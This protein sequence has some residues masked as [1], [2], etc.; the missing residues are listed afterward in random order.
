MSI[1]NDEPSAS[2]TETLVTPPSC[3]AGVQQGSP[4]FTAVARIGNNLAGGFWEYSINAKTGHYAYGPTN[5]PFDTQVVAF[6][7]Q[8]DPFGSPVTASEGQVTVANAAPLVVQA[9]PFT[10]ITAVNV[11]ADVN[12]PGGST[13]LRAE[14]QSLS[15]DFFSDSDTPYNYP[16]QATQVCQLPIS[17]VTPAA[18]G[19]GAWFD[20]R[21]VLPGAVSGAIY[22]V[23]M[24]LNGSIQLS[25]SA[26]ST[27]L[28]AAQLSVTVKVYA[29]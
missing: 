10:Q 5:Q 2:V 8:I 11:R 27:S 1:V 29:T 12:R 26:N 23:R 20:S 7:L 24:S 28:T 16:Q 25:S 3:S 21:I 14:W 15:I 13:T 19:A 18:P 4:L 17:A 9:N 22:P 6:T